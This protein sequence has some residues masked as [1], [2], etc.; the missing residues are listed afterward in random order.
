MAKT[1]NLPELEHEIL[2]F[3]K[4]K[5]IFGEVMKARANGEP[6]VFYDGPPFTTGSPHYGHIMQMANKDAVLR[7]KT[8]QGFQVPRTIGW[9]THGLPVE[10]QLEKELGLKGGKRAIIDFGIENFVTAARKIVLRTVDEWEATMKR[11]GRWVDTSHP[12]TTMDNT[13]MESVWWAF[14]QLYEQGLVYKD[15]RVSPYCPR[16]GTVLSNF[17]LNQGY[18]DNVA[19]TS[20]YA[21]LKV[22]SEGKF[23]Y[24]YLVFWTTTP[25]STFGVVAMAVNPS[26]DYVTIEN[27]GDRYILAQAQVST[28]F[29]E[30]E[31]GESFKGS[32]L[33][34][35]TYEPLYKVNDESNLHRVVAGDHVTTEDG[36][37]IASIAPA[38][39][40]IDAEVGKRE[41]LSMVQTVN[42]DGTVKSGWHL[43]GEGKFV[44]EAEADII[45]D[46]KERGFLVKAEEIRHT[47]PF[48][49]RCDT[50]LLYYPATSWY[51][52][53]TAIKDK[54]LAENK[55]IHWLPEHLR[56]GRFGKWLEGARDWAVSR[57]RFWGAPLPVWECEHGHVRVL[58]SLQDD[59]QL[60]KLMDLHR[61]YIDEVTLSCSE[62]EAPMQR[63]SFVFDCWFESGSMPYAQWHYPFEH[64]DIFNPEQGKGYPADF[65]AEALDQTRGWFYTLHVLGV[66]LFGERAYKNL[67]VSGLILAPDGKKLSKSLRNYVDPNVLFEQEGVD[68][69]R[70][71]LFTS[72]TLGE[73]YRFSDEAVRDV[74]RR[75]L[76]PLFNV[77]EYYRLSLVEKDETE[78]TKPEHAALDSW[79]KARVAQARSQVF[80]AMD[81][82]DKRS[83][84]DLVRACRTFGPLVED[85]STWYVRLSR[86]RKD[87][88]FTQTLQEVLTHISTTYAPFLPF[89]M[90]HVYQEIGT[91][92]GGHASVHLAIFHSLVDWQDEESLKTMEQ[93]RSIVS[94]GRELRARESV[95]QR[96]PLALVQ[97][98]LKGSLPDWAQQLI[99]QELNIKKLEI[100]ESHNPDFAIS[101]DIA[102]HTEISEELKQEGLA[103]NVRRLIQDLRKQANLMPS[104]RA[105]AWVSE[106]DAT[107]VDLIQSQLQTTTITT[108]PQVGNALAETTYSNNDQTV[109]VKLYVAS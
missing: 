3:W 88:A 54:L 45:A 34:G 84:F 87:K 70:L 14:K 43:P 108:A 16:C 83:P 77:L 99:C 2:S 33:V 58:G 12:Y 56:D 29:P 95:N 61:P 106:T 86:G 53:V 104:D 89:A 69:L 82:G 51:V 76:V 105:V 65:I 35:L 64:E 11:M 6:F 1:P 31:P 68:A 21:K 85:V 57:D 101:G 102:L 18:K 75:W 103:N 59:P 78:E 60:A 7:Y 80:E 40:E 96:Q 72:A 17:E 49:W 98:M 92:A 30:A 48:C 24:A 67:I 107:L 26:A 32:D 44:K 19:D 5:D 50:P 62:C 25:W 66:A 47:Y 13:Y 79:I 97:V 94:V 39:G 15:F 22:T 9:D 23:K 63:V 81:G 71:F 37:G 100:V 93:I 109:I 91:N 10:Y 27:E 36:T 74:K 73:D 42:P 4:E 8:M 20:I 41:Q 28:V 55:K 46:L 52:K 90:E 38:Y